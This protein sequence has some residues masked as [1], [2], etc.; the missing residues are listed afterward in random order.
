MLKNWVFG[1]VKWHLFEAR[2]EL[3]KGMDIMGKVSELK[4][5]PIKFEMCGTSGS[6]GTMGANSNFFRSALSQ[7][8]VYAVWKEDKT[9][10][11]IANC[12]GVSPVYVESE[13]EYL[14][15]YG[16]LIETK[17][18]F[19]CNILLDEPTNEIIDLHDEMYLKAAKL[20]ANDLYDELINSGI[21]NDKRILCGQTDQ[22]ISMTATERADDNFILWALIP[23]IAALSGENLM[24]KSISFDEAATIRPD[25]GHNIC[26]ASIMGTGIKRPM[27][28][29]SMLRWNGPCWYGRNNI[30]WQID[31]EWS[32][33]R[34]DDRYFEK[35]NHVLSLFSREMEGMLEEDEYIYI[36]DM[37]MVKTTC[38]NTG[39]KSVWQIV[40][41]MDIDIKNE[42][43]ALETAS[44]KS[45]GPNLMS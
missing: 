17:G 37:G 45:T 34:V 10:N 23:Y 30:L 36:A 26:Y 3:K 29:D 1:T 18:K 4:F 33:R 28:F 39:F 2:K 43:V 25:G 22:P 41:L 42:L 15:E 19:R 44:K 32:G 8:I 31:S 40:C 35:A 16:F 14:A 5:N 20:F 24:D 27:Y 7:S 11:E 21:L 12:L 13:A 38:D 9:I 6:L